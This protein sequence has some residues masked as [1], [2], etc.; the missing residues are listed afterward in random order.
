M[1]RNTATPATSINQAHLRSHAEQK[2]P[3]QGD[4]S[5]GPWFLFLTRRYAPTSA[6]SGDD[7]AS[8]TNKL[9][10][11]I[12]DETIFDGNAVHNLGL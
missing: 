6:L 12:Q 2:P 11:Y 4:G 1:L 3:T 8:P 10:R 7:F 9:E 5:D